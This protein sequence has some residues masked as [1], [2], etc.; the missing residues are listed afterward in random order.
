MKKAVKKE[1]AKKKV[2]KKAKATEKTKTI[3]TII[4]D[5]QNIKLKSNKKNIDTYDIFAAIIG[6]TRL[7]N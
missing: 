7:I 1:V 3:F 2:T 4:I 6:L 5:G